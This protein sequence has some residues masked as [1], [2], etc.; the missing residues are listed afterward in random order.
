[1]QFLLWFALLLL[2]RALRRV[3]QALPARLL[4]LKNKSAFFADVLFQNGLQ[5]LE[6][7]IIVN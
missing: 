2:K 4:N 1:M 5:K 3:L 6:E 7:A